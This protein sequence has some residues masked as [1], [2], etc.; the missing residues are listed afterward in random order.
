MSYRTTNPTGA[1]ELIEGEEDWTVVDVRTVEEF[2]EAHI[3]G[4]FN[5]PF[6]FKGPFGMEPNPTFGDT[7]GR[8][9]ASDARLVLV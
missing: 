2:D 9:F 5:V 6:A 1:R 4:A 3:P 7:I 8:L